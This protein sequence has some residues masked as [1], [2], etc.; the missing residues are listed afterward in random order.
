MASGLGEHI[1]VLERTL[2][3]LVNLTQFCVRAR[4][5]NTE[6]YAAAAER[7]ALAIPSLRYI[8]VRISNDHMD[9]LDLNDDRDY[10]R[11]Y[12]NSDG[13]AKLER[14]EGPRENEEVELYR[15][16]LYVQAGRGA[17]SG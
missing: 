3:R 11:I 15:V 6:S 9:L 4:G 10:R 14:L 8:S 16:F 1:E 12:R 13:T 5:Y 2:P 17:M 7:L